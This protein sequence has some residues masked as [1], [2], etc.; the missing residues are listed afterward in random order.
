MMTACMHA[1][2]TLFNAESETNFN[3][4]KKMLSL[5]VN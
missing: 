3:T 5:I 2:V 4:D 1:H